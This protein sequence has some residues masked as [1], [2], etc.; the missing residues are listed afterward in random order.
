M[1]DADNKKKKHEAKSGIMNSP[2]FA[3]AGVKPPVYDIIGKRLREYYDGVSQQPVPDRFLDLLNQL[4]AKT[5]K[6]DS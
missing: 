6:K 3:A 5:S 4:E 1:G 2:G